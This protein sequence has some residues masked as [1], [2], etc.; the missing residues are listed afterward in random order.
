[1]ARQVWR[2]GPECIRIAGEH[3]RLRTQ[4]EPVL[5]PHQALQQP[6]AEEAGPAGDEYTFAAQLVPQVAGVVQHMIQ[7]AGERVL[8][9]PYSQASTR[10]RSGFT[11]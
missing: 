8:C 7:V 4:P 9:H 3:D 1:M 2:P 10:M 5:C 11:P 6:A